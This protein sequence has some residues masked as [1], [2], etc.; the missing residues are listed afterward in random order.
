[1]E[2]QTLVEERRILYLSRSDL[3]AAGILDYAGIVEDVRQ[4]L[5]HSRGET[6]NEK[7][8][9][10]FDVDRDWKV[11]ALIG[12]TGSYAGLK[13]LGA[14]TDN[15]SLLLPRSNSIIAL[16]D[17]QTGRVLCVMD[18][19]LI[20]TLRTGAYAALVTDVLA[21][22]EPATVGLIGAG[23]IARCA[24]LCMAATVR[25]RISSVLV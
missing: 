1:M 10:D 6:V 15:L 25:Q 7:T 2:L 12:V 8:A 11:S 21:P 5:L 23:V 14:N 18:G 17:R 22:P 16:N 24:L 13:W 3:I 20:S 4:G 9:I 19:T